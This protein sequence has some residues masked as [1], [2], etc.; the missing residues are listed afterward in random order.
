MSAG[1]TVNSLSQNWGTPQKYVD[2]VK[3]AF[4]GK[5]DLDPCSNDYSIVNAIT[6]YRLPL[7][8]GL[9]ESWK[10]PTIFVNPPYGAD[11]KRNTT[12]K[13]WLAKCCKAHY[14]YNSEVIALVPVASNTSHWKKYVFGKA[15][16][17][18]FLYDTRLKFLV[19][20]N[21][22]GKGAP[23]SCAM[24]YWGTNEKKFHDVFIEYGAVVNISDLINKEIGTEN[25]QINHFILF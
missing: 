8:D 2:A 12:I 10:Y 19:N 20:G 24:I 4:N 11:R 22:G 18:C 9:K 21:G 3:K 1:R 16:A 14:D 6:E 7:I 13:N 17:V 15:H 23:M 5:I 25:K